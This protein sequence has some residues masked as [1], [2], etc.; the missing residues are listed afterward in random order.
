MEYGGV[1]ARLV[2]MGPPLIPRLLPESLSPSARFVVHIPIKRGRKH[3]S[4]GRLQTKRVDVVD[5]D[6]QAP[7][8]LTLGDE[9]EL[10]D[11]FHGIDRIA[12][13]GSEAHDL[14]F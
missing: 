5:E 1:N 7:D 9:P 2:H 14:C 4:L 6:E 13:R 10:T 12:A 8:L 3:K 11:L